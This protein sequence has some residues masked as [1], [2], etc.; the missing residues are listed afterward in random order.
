MSI[1]EHIDKLKQLKSNFKQEFLRKG[2]DLSQEEFSNYYKHVSSLGTS[3]QL[4]P[5]NLYRE[6]TNLIIEDNNN[7]SFATC[8]EIYDNGVKIDE[9]KNKSYSIQNLSCGEHNF[10]VIAKGENFI[11]SENSNPYYYPVFS[12][13]KSYT[14]II[15][16]YNFNVGTYQTVTD[17]LSVTDGGYL[18][19]EV[20]VLVGGEVG[21]YVYNCYTGELIISNVTGEVEVI[22]KSDIYPILSCPILSV[23]DWNIWWEAVENASLYRIYAN[24]EIALE[25]EST[26]VDLRN[27]LNLG[28][29]YEIKVSCIAENYQES[30]LSEGVVVEVQN[31]A[32]VYGVTGLDDLTTTN[33]TRTFDAQVLNYYYN[34]SSGEIISD[35]DNVFPYNEM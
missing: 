15:S 32:P 3:L 16:S 26:Y 9:I 5:V 28:Q 23:N 4:Y 2:V 10:Y 17:Y 21:E 11:A 18:P 20:T 35:F 13:T 31:Y 25:T 29:T 22:A 24:G 12:Y 27:C 7:G 6:Y 8:Y 34:S 30:A 14:G 19:R 1:Y 33:L